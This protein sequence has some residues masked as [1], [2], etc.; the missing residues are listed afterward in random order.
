MDIYYNETHSITFIKISNDSEK[1]NDIRNTWTNF[2]LVPSSRP[3][4]IT[5]KPRIQLVS[6]PRSNRIIDLSEALTNGCAYDSR[7][8]DWDFYVDH[9]EYDS[10]ADYFNEICDYFDGSQFKV[11]LEDQPNY[12]YFGKVYITKFKS[13]EDYSVFT[14]HYNFDAESQE[15]IWNLD[16]YNYVG[17]S[18]IIYD[19][20]GDRMLLQDGSITV[21]TYL[22]NIIKVKIVSNKEWNNYYIVW[23][24]P[25][26]WESMK[27]YNPLRMTKKNSITNSYE[28]IGYVELKG[29]RE[30]SNQTLYFGINTTK[31]TE[32]N[33]DSV[34]LWVYS[35]NT[36]N[37]IY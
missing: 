19:T 9:G 33:H 20:N 29:D 7:E 26:G 11:I 1:T 14:I 2:H 3:Y 25:N 8:G 27:I 21:R 4:V 28:H 5:P 30:V 6:L 18:S 23:Y 10:W 12:T 16:Y 24:H 13:G 37:I 15:S 34:D 32:Y 17:F 22:P 36:R 31:D 35:R